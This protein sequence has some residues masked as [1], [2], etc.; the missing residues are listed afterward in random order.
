MKKLL[1]VAVPAGLAVLAIA[2]LLSGSRGRADAYE[3]RLERARLK[4]DFSERAGAA[5]TLPADRL[6]EWRDE[7][8]ALSRWYFDE[9]QA[10]RNRHPAEPPRPSGVEAAAADRKGKLDEK[11]RAQLE[12]FQ[13][14]ADGRLALLREAHYAPVQSMIAE[15]LRLDLVAVEA[16]SPP[17][18]GAP[19][20]RI[21]FAL[22]GAP[23]FVEREKGGERTTVVRNVVP[24][25]FRRIAFHFLDGQGKPYGEMSGGGEPYQ[26]LSDPERFQDD[27]PPGVLFGTWF[28][29]LFPREATTVNLEIQADVRGASGAIRPVTFLSQIPVPD[30][31]KL[32][33]GA[34][35]QAEVR[36]AAASAP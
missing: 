18:G 20:L 19:G 36:E 8:A 15:G 24:V 10:I 26:K 31:W 9:L 7:I 12:D 1:F 23:R 30:A 5:R 25:T 11:A 29:E 35:F 17:E 33:P 34:V 16:G 6:P 32:P 27:F 3:A 28:V 22:W 13:R 2:F 14:Y 21:D 4:R